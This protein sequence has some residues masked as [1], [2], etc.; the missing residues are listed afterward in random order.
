MFVLY[1]HFRS[2]TPLPKILVLSNVFFSSGSAGAATI[3]CMRLS[4]IDHP[5]FG[6][7]AI[8]LKHLFHR[9]HGTQKWRSR[10]AAEEKYHRLV[11]IELR[12]LRLLLAIQRLQLKV[13][14]LIT[15][16]QSVRIAKPIT[17]SPGALP[18]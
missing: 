10:V 9:P 14:S 15:R 12:Q 8:L 18:Q 2:R 1:Q 6:D 4:Y 7:V 5:K 17:A 11:G 13:G 16:F 3:H